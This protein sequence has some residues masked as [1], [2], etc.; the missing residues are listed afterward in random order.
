[1]R[2]PRHPERPGSS[3]PPAECLSSPQTGSQETQGGSRR[4]PLGRHVQLQPPSMQAQRPRWVCQY[5]RLES[6][7]VLQQEADQRE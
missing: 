3:R 6:L 2:L 1:M 7:P 5:E 4:P